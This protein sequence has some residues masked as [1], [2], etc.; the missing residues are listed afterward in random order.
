MLDELSASA[1]HYGTKNM[2][3][4]L[5][6]MHA[7]KLDFFLMFSAWADVLWLRTPRH[8]QTSLAALTYKAG[9]IA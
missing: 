1:V 9:A 6:A 5:R 7:N 8:Y 4:I 2:T 3:P